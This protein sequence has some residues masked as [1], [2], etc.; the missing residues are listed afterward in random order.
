M[1]KLLIIVAV[2]GLA[3][4]SSWAAE[5]P[6]QQKEFKTKLVK[7]ACTKG[8][9]KEAKAV[10][11]KFMQDAK[12]LSCNACHT[13]LAPKYELAKDGL[14]QFKKAGGKLLSDKDDAAKPK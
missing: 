10:M 8:G 14:D 6:C 1:S 12:L 9:Q 2:L 5:E 11:K 13:K 7:D 3:S 4:V